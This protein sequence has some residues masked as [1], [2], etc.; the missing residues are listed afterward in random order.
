MKKA[1]R[2][3]VDS[4][5]ENRSG[6]VAVRWFDNRTVDLLSSYTGTEPMTKVKR[7]D[8]K[9]KPIVSV[10]C[11]AIVIEYNKFMRRIDLHDSLTALYR[12]SIKSRRWYMYTLN[13]MVVSAWL[14]HRRQ[15]ILLN[16]P[17]VKLSKFHAI[18]AN[19]LV[20][21][22]KTGGPSLEATPPAQKKKKGVQEK[23]PCCRTS[24]GEYWA[25]AGDQREQR[26][27]QTKGSHW[28]HT[29]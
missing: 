26:S 20:N 3:A 11:P 19:Q 4:L 25:L 18:L 23:G 12:Y 24:L 27:M 21:P 17:S 29:N 13:M 10:E 8:K 16:V 15:A 1:G 5:L 22:P 14:R 28:L 9:Q 2:G 7:Y 6:C